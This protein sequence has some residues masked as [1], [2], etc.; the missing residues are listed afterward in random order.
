MEREKTGD[1]KMK[2]IMKKTLFIMLLSLSILSG[3]GGGSGGGGETAP[4]LDTASGEHDLYMK[5][6]PD[7]ITATRV[8][9]EWEWEYTV[10][11]E[12]HSEGQVELTDIEM[13][14]VD[15]EG[16]LVL[17]EKDS[18][19]FRSLDSGLGIEIRVSYR[20]SVPPE[21]GFVTYG[22]MING[23]A[24]VST[25]AEMDFTTRD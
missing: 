23:E 5:I 11:L 19:F 7:V 10:L 6:N 24:W 22:V 25:H 4:V 18:N 1:K 14:L 8:G 16:K 3:C 21:S 13:E 15:Q 9:N 2:Q 20:D 17:S 12:N